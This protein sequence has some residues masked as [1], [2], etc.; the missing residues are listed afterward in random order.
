[1][2]GTGRPTWHG[3]RGYLVGWW[4]PSLP[5]FLHKTVKTSRNEQKQ[6]VLTVLRVLANSETGRVA[7]GGRP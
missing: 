6:T 2:Y 5:S 3:G 1:M 7:L 4:V